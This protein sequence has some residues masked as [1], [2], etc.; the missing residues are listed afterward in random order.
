MYCIVGRPR[1][2]GGRGLWAE[3]TAGPVT[4]ASVSARG[5]GPGAKLATM[6]VPAEPAVGGGRYRLLRSIGR[7]GTAE[8]FEAEDSTNASIVALKCLRAEVAGARRHAALLER[9]YYTLAQLAHPFVVTA[10]DFGVDP[11]IGNY[12]TM[13]LLA[14]GDLH[15]GAPLHYSS[16]CL[17]ARDVCSALSLLHSR[18][19]VHRDLT[20]LNIRRTAEGRAKLIDFGAMAAM[21]P[22]KVCIGT[23]PV[24]PPEVVRMQELDARSDL[25]AL[26]ATLYCTLAGRYPYPAR[27]FTV[28][29][30]MWQRPLAPPSAFVADLPP[31]IDDLIL[32]LLQLDPN[33][34]PSSAA[35]VIERLNAAAELP[36]DEVGLT[37]RSYLATPR[38]VGREA[39]LGAVRDHV[40]RLGRGLG[41]VVLITGSP[42]VGRTRALDASVIEGKLGGACVA[43]ADAAAAAGH[44]YAVA[45]ALMARLLATMPGAAGKDSAAYRA[46]CAHWPELEPTGAD[47]DE[48]VPG[49]NTGGDDTL[50]D[51]VCN[52]LLSLS[53]EQPLMLVVDDAHAADQPSLALLAL[54]SEAAPE[55]PV[56]IALSAC[57]D[58]PSHSR[59]LAV[60][61][62]NAWQLELQSLQAGETEQLLRSVFGDIPNVAAL[63]ERLHQIAEG[64]PRDVLELAQDLVDRGVAHHRAGAWTLPNSHEQLDLP[65]SMLNA[66]TDRTKRLS[67]SARTLADALA[68]SDVHAFSLEECAGLLGDETTDTMAH[69]DE[70]LRMGLVV[71]LEE[72]YA[73]RGQ[74]TVQV[75]RAHLQPDRDRHRAL[76]EVFERRGDDFRAAQHLLLAD[77]AKRALDFL[78]RHALHSQALTD[79]D[80]KAYARLLRT[81]PAGWM[82]VYEQAL[83]QC[84]KHG[85][86]AHDQYVLRR[87]LTGLAAYDSSPERSRPHFVALW[88]QLQQDCGLDLY[89]DLD[90]GLPSQTRLERAIAQ[91]QQR[92]ESLP[93]HER[94]LPPQEA[95]GK[96]ATSVFSYIGAI[97]LSSDLQMWRLLPSLRPLIPL[98]PSLDVIQR[99]VDG[100]G[101]RLVGRTEAARAIYLAVLHR[102]E[103][104]DHAGLED[105]YWK[106][107]RAGMWFVLSMLDSGMG[108]ASGLHWAEAL[109]GDPLYR[110]NTW[111]GRMMH[112]LW[113]GNAPAAE[114]ARVQAERMTLR[115]LEGM[116]QEGLHLMR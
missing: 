7:G 10:Y 18:R 62:N 25:Y 46:V 107:A 57:T 14:G 37:E 53:R 38:L 21:G 116:P 77:Q 34:R 22:S 84:A 35:E 70:L 30:Q 20:P 105:T 72:R 112:H 41:S 17:L 68:T 113:Q 103:A 60:L 51:E 15:Q 3:A 61:R 59:A 9:E 40:A 79:V 96:L 85:H 63:A 42:G 65:S 82:D 67:D 83:S 97:V 100:V 92:Y 1:K 110:A 58:E 80:A 109:E 88:K 6:G 44:D 93:E 86:T 36:P 12:Y 5:W 33:A 111:L 87:R 108:L 27:S 102:L 73:L 11:R 69:I 94:V 114:Q 89:A 43:R 16:A 23:P 81:L 13:E 104:S 66:L 76:G 101:L 8:V 19:L 47:D 48:V 52:L 55:H 39:L 71:P 64:K 2:R 91:A 95:A 49:A 24:C 106:T 29:E 99:I 28:L 32:D 78:I 50:R 45:R 98:S 31:A 26:G 74:A 56:V 115:Q 75:L 4:S 54:L 90:A